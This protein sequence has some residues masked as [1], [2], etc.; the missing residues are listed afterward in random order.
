MKT[1]KN[2]YWSHSEKITAEEFIRRIAPK[3]LDP[4]QTMQECDGDMWM[5]DYRKL[6]DASAKL[7]NAIR[8]LDEEASRKIEGEEYDS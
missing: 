2:I 4:V 7:S 5:S 8:E 3:I 6:T 1:E